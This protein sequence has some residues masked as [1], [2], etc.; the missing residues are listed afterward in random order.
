MYRLLVPVTL[1]TESQH[2]YV[3]PEAV[4]QSRREAIIAK[5]LGP[6]AKFKSGGDDDAL[7]LVTGRD[8]VE[9]QRWKSDGI[10]FVTLKGPQRR[11]T[12]LFDQTLHAKSLTMSQHEF[13]HRGEILLLALLRECD[14]CFRWL[15][16]VRRLD[17]SP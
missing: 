5:Y 17:C 6:P 3:K 13:Q 14:G 2:T 9:Q 10:E 4:N 12:R 7:P 8:D 11:K 1:S 16:L 15:C